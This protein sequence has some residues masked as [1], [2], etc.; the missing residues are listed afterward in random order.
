MDNKIV[1]ISGGH[2]ESYSIVS[3]LEEAFTLL[4]RSLASSAQ[5]DDVKS[6]IDALKTIA[7]FYKLL[8]PIKT[9]LI[10]DPAAIQIVTRDNKAVFVPQLLVQLDSRNVTPSQPLTF[11]YKPES[12]TRIALHI[13]YDTANYVAD[14]IIQ[15]TSLTDDWCISGHGPALDAETHASFLK[16]ALSS[17]GLC[18]KAER[19]FPHR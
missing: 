2:Q 15:W 1:S 9:S 3:M 6:L 18:E 10:F 16:S 4:P 17:A 5:H 11:R 14:D 19:A 13:A 7:G 8:A 12:R